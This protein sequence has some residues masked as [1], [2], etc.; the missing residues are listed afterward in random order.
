MRVRRVLLCIFIASACFCRQ[1]YTG[2][3]EF[4]TRKI[5]DHIYLVGTAAGFGENQL[6]MTSEKGL[7][8]FNTFWSEITAKAFKDRIAEALGRDDYAYVI[9]MTDRLDTFGGN[10]AY[11][12]A[13]IVGHR[14]FLDKYEGKEKE[15]AAEIAELV[16]MWRYKED[17]SRD[18]LKEHAPGSDEEKSEIRWMNQCKQL[19][20]ELEEGFSLVLPTKVYDDRITL[21]LGDLT[22]KLLWFGRAGYDGLSVAVVPKEKIAIIPRSIMHS[23]HLAPYPHFRYATLDIPRWIDVLEEMLSGPDAVETVICDINKVWPVERARTHLNYIKTLWERVRAA[24]AAGKDIAEIQEQ[25]SLDN[26]FAFV[27]DM[28]GYKN[29]GDDWFRPQHY[30]HVWLFFVQGKNLASEIIRNEGKDSVR[31]VLSKVRKLRDSGGDVYIDEASI[32]G[33][34]YEMLNASRFSDAIEVFRFNV[35]MFPGSA[36]VYDSL[37]EA[38]MKSGDNKM[39]IENYEKSLELNPENE[40]AKEMLKK[41]TGKSSG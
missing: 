14:A 33:L 1:D 24:D 6:V 11:K 25:L 18:R 9:N 20:E 32:N 2:A 12:D 19:A 38:Y 31:D 36:N 26:E 23:Q 27:K 40:N 39:A 17:V 16:D 5:T 8:V 13:T 35:E 4:E 3:Q 15:V 41:L 21:D 7:V 22:L 10:A 34:G 30:W 29:W 28:Q 37:A